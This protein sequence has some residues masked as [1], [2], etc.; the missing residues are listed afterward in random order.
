MV[1]MMQGTDSRY[2]AR[3]LG[4]GKHDLE[5]GAP[6]EPRVSGDITG[7]LLKWKEGYESALDELVVMVYEDLRKIAR[8]HLKGRAAAQTIQ[9]TALINEVYLRFRKSTSIRFRCRAQFF[10]FAGQLMRRIL[11]DYLRAR[12]AGKRGAAYSPASLSQIENISHRQDL[13]LST[14]LALD[15]ALGKLETVDP[16]QSRIVEL[17]FFAGLT[18]EEIMEAMALSRSTVKREWQTA[19][20]GLPASCGAREARESVGAGLGGN[21]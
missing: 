5:D 4:E 16:R 1:N 13:E 15:R 6:S 10:G 20:F 19:L 12:Q 7:A 3:R 17:R 9:T 2:W 21:A 8:H 11:V 14:L 18:M